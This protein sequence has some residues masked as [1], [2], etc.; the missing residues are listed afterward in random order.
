MKLY[1]IKKRI[2]A[3]VFLVGILSFSVLNFINSR[4]ELSELLGMETWSS[5][6]DVLKV[7]KELDAEITENLYKRMNFIEGYAYVQTLLG[8]RESN[9]FSYI[10]DEDGFLH[11]ASFFREEEKDL[12]E[13]ALRLKR[14]QDYVSQNGT[15]L[16]FV[17]TPGKYVQGET[18]L[19]SGMPIND[20]N[21]VVDETLF[22]MNRLGI[23]TLDLR[24]NLPNK[25][26]SYQETFFRTDHHW[27][28][29]AAFYATKVLVET[30]EERFGENLDPTGYY[31]DIENYTSVIYQKGMLGSMGRR[32]GVN[33]CGLEDFEALWPNFK[34]EYYRES[35]RE[36]GYT[37]KLKGDFSKSI[38]DTDILTGNKGIYSDSQYSV[39]LNGLSPY[40]HVENLTRK[41]GSKIFMIRDSYFSPVMSFLIPMCKSIDAIWSLEEMH[42]LDIETYVKENTFDYIIME[43]YPYNIS[44][45]AFNFFKEEAR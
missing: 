1:M 22:Y 45:E 9:N 12:F 3:A 33:F 31:T 2:F 36:K 38:M 34:G 20:P 39:Y 41:E 16:I 7:P 24:E 23:E 14:M 4:E 27:T 8:K 17:V 37:L 40:D 19:R 35:L 13:Y 5:Y 44:D 28:I 10:K 30:I 18:H 6:A 42:E 32:T 25:D 43:I 29:P 11:Y 26:L 21:G 15:K